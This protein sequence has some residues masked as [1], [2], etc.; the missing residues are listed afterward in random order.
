MTKS[1]FKPELEL[2]EFTLEDI[3]TASSAVVTTTS[4]STTASHTTLPGSTSPSTTSGGVSIGGG[5]GDIY[6]DISDFFKN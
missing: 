4:P 5:S 2:V 6:I 3:I 1:Y